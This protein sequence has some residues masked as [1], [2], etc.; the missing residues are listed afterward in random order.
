MMPEMTLGVGKGRL[1]WRSDHPTPSPSP[2]FQDREATGAPASTLGPVRAS[3]KG[4][5]PPLP[6]PR[7]PPGTP[8][9]HR[10]A[11]SG[12]QASWQWRL[13]Q[14]WADGQSYKGENPDSKAALLSYNT[15]QSCLGN[16]PE[17]G[18][19]PAS[20]KRTSDAEGENKTESL[21]ANFTDI[22]TG[23]SGVSGTF[24]IKTCDLTDNAQGLG[25][26]V[27][28]TINIKGGGYTRFQA[29]GITLH[30]CRSRSVL[31]RACGTGAAFKKQDGSQRG[32][33]KGGKA[34]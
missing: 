24:Q 28:V 21:L 5:P 26:R 33:P 9:A 27:S 25:L 4:R 8:Q 10:A 23:T 14:H 1:Q 31:P 11:V 7:P 34:L 16:E 15:R 30:T 18:G 2:N 12:T 13:G 6:G 3:S 32:A 29:E 20:E 17:T 19:L 22:K